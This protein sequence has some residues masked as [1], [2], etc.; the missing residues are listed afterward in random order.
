MWTLLSRLYHNYMT[1]TL[2]T[3][4][5]IL[6]AHNLWKS[7]HI[8]LTNYRRYKNIIYSIYASRC[9]SCWGMN[10]GDIYLVHTASSFTRTMY[11]QLS[12]FNFTSWTKISISA[13]MPTQYLRET[14]PIL[15]LMVGVLVLCRIL[16][17]VPGRK[18]GSLM[19][20]AASKYSWNCSSDDTYIKTWRGCFQTVAYTSS[21]TCHITSRVILKL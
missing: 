6:V 1:V 9:I 3:Y 13:T 8:P 21:A 11:Y 10:D 5:Q 7:G 16:A 2:F 15:H 14:P 19:F 18:E 17:L 20:S 12:A 4:N